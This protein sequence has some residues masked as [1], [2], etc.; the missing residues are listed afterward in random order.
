MTYY[1]I[2]ILSFFYVFF[3]VFLYLLEKKIN[4]FEKEILQDFK[5][6]NNQI[7]S[8]YEIT[9]KYLNKHNEIFKEILQLKKKDFAENNIYWKLIEKSNINTLIHN[10]FNFIFRVCNKNQKLNKDHKFLFIR[11][12]IINKS[13]KLGEKLKIYK[14]ITK[15]YNFLILLKN[16]TIIWILFPIYKKEEI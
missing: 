4:I 13:L 3:I 12:I 9:E 16:L 5:E 7:P 10:E 14:K 6:K 15:Q 1:I 2:L 11:D 8:I